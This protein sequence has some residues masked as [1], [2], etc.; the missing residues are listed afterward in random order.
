MPSGSR[1]LIGSSNITVSGSPI[2]AAAMPSRWLMPS[3][4]VPTRLPAT[5]LRPTRSSTSVTRRRSMPLVS[6]SHVEVVG[7]APAPDDG[8]G[9]QQRPHRTEGVG[10]LGVGLAIDPD[11]ARGR[12]VQAQDHAH[13][14]RLARPVGAEEAGDLSWSD[15]EGDPV[16]RHGLA[17]SLGQV[18][19][20]DH[21]SS[22]R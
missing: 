2:R 16:D 19:C 17:V 22:F 13:G 10:Q 3:E 15:G 9:V 20:L 7:G 6:A 1:P 11:I 5:S 8:A 12:G 21:C 14:G 18:L 4:K